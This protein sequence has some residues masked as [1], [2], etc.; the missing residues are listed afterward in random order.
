VEG[1]REPLEVPEELLP[2]V[3]EDAVAD[4]G[5]PD[6]RVIVGEGPE[7]GHGHHHEHGE[8]EQRDRGDAG[9]D[10]GHV[11]VAPGTVDQ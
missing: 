2:D 4:Q 5:E 11:V 6:G 9:Q 10:G 8:Q 7:G 3:G 1:Q